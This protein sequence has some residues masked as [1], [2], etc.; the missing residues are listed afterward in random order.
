MKDIKDVCSRSQKRSKR[1]ALPSPDRGGKSI[2]KS[3]NKTSILSLL[4]L[5]YAPQ[6]IRHLGRRTSGNAISLL[7]TETKR[8]R[9]DIKNLTGSRSDSAVVVIGQTLTPG[10]RDVFTGEGDEFHPRTNSRTS[11]DLRGRLREA[12]IC[13]RSAPR[14]QARRQFPETLDYICRGPRP[15]APRPPAEPHPISRLL[16]L[17]TGAAGAHLKAW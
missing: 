9:V 3:I 15:A 13:I 8:R 2:W 11:L 6:P 16:L 7:M 1:T 5:G 14:L 4:H 17:V 10:K 12:H